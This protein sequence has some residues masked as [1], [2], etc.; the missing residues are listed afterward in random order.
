MTEKSK[1]YCIQKYVRAASVKEAIEKESE[2]QIESVFVSEEKGRD[3][4][5]DAIGFHQ[6]EAKHYYEIG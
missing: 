6:F 3:P 4:S 1:R 5:V 2:S